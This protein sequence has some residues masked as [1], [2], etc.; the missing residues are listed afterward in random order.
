MQFL[1]RLVE[2][3]FLQKRLS[4]V[5]AAVRA[6]V[7]L[8]CLGF[9]CHVGAQT[10]DQ[11]LFL[12]QIRPSVAGVLGLPNE[13]FS[14]APLDARVRTQ[15][16]LEAVNVDFPFASRETIRVRCSNPSE[17][18]LYLRVVLK[19]GLKPLHLNVSKVN[20]QSEKREVVVS[21]FLI[22]RGTPLRAEMF[23]VVEKEFTNQ[24]PLLLSSVKD[25]G[26]TALVRD[27]MPGVPV[28]STDLKQ[29]VLVKRG[30]MV[31]L[32]ISADGKMVISARLEALQDGKM[33]EQ[34]KLRNRES[35]RFISGVVVGLNMVEGM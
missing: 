5:V 1:C 27:L 2:L 12:D 26:N 28:R 34:V 6:S 18:Q 35:G 4:P 9:S 20:P 3:F 21:K 11:V 7:L 31:L 14:F 29:A 32:K 15:S 25:L 24:D 10:K 30:Q 19:E 22:R 8:V 16:C 23:E 13:S 17:W 33:G